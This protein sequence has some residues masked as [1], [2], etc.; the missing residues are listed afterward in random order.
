MKRVA[1]LAL[2]ALLMT[3]CAQQTDKNSIFE[4]DINTFCDN[5][6]KIDA[7]INQISN[8]SADEEG[9]AAAK[10]D[11][12]KCL[13][14]LNDQFRMFANMDFPEEYDYLEDMADEASEYMIEAVDTY[15]TM[16]EDDGYNVNLEEYADENYA[17]AYKRVRIIT[18]LLRGETPNEEGLTIQ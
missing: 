15:H 3:G 6:V 17:R 4:S 18:A 1:L 8:I 12:L 11:L 9:L 13:D 14:Q 10:A 7:S 16:Y 2:S 5:I